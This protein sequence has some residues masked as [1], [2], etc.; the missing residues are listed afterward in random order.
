MRP[1]TR[2]AFWL[3]VLVTS[4]LILGVT[5]AQS[6]GTD[7]APAA[8]AGNPLAL[9]P[10]SPADATRGEAI[11]AKGC[12]GCHG[13]QGRSQNPERPSLA[14]QHPRYL[15]VQLAA[16]RAKLRPSAVMQRVASGLS[17]QDIVDVAA[18]YA[19][20]TPREP[21]ETDAAVAARGKVFY[22]EGAVARNVTACAVCHGENGRGADAL[23]IP[24]ITD[25]TPRYVLN[26][27]GQYKSVPDFKVAWP[28][29]MHIVTA[30]MTDAE[31]EEV[32]AYVASMGTGEKK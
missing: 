28:N 14:A 29:S 27:L 2:T 21:W 18:Y 12:Q 7:P 30:A 11:A 1:A 26:M 10:A 8:P 23:G 4:A 22:A 24:S 31:M 32:S 13:P 25:Q 15:T 16:F 6:Q 3:P 5:T 9:N 19:Q 17:D 20:Q